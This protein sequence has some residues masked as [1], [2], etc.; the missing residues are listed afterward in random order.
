MRHLLPSIALLLGTTL[1]ACH[2]AAAPPARL[3]GSGAVGDSGSFGL[4]VVR[5]EPTR[6]RAT[7]TLDRPA[8]VVA[9]VVS[10]GRS[11]ELATTDV[12]QATMRSSAG[13]HVASVT[14]PRPFDRP[15]PPTGAVDEDA[16]LARRMDYDRCVSNLA[17]R[18]RAQEQRSSTQRDSAGRPVNTV[19]RA[20]SGVDPQTAAEQRCRG[21]LE[22]PRTAGP[23]AERERPAGLRFLL[24]LA[25]ANPLPTL[26]LATRIDALTVK[27][28]D[29]QGTMAAVAEGIFADGGTQWSGVYVPW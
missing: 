14:P 28:D 2:H 13:R 23:A 5:A 29:V 12:R 16:S 15:P 26:E 7:Y 6:Q 3:P 21:L 24:L 1:G 27:A 4:R 20:G 8:Y 11:I 19:D 10:P 18:L 25:S 17:A 9:L 22:A